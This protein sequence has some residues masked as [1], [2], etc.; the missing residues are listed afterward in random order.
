MQ[1]SRFI[2]RVTD[3]A[4]VSFTLDGETVVAQAGD[5]VAA[6][7]VAHNAS[8]LRHT[9]L[10]GAPRTPYCMMGVCFECLVEIN[11]RPNVQSC[12]IEVQDGMQV[13]RMHGFR[14]IEVRHG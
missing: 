4:L 8:P 1:D 7:L 3:K 6:A 12:L 5:T 11:G 14:K 9:G 2:R 13:R 10:S